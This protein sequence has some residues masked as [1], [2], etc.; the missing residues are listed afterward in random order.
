[1]YWAIGD[2]LKKY[3]AKR[4]IVICGSGYNSLKWSTIISRYSKISF[5]IPAIDDVEINPTRHYIVICEDVYINHSKKL[6]NLGFIEIEDYYDWTKYD[7]TSGH[8]PVDVEYNGI[9]IG[10]GSYFSFQKDNLKNIKTIGRF[11]SIASTAEVHGNHSMNRLTTS[12]LYPLLEEQATVIKNNAPT[13]KDPLGTNRKVDIGNDVWIGANSFIN[14][15]KVSKIG[16]GA[17][18]G[19]GSLVTHDVHPYAI[20]Y[21]SPAKVV[22]YRFSEKQIAVLELVKWWEWDKKQLNENIE[23]LMYPEMFF[24]RFQEKT[25]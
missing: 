8:L 22:R 10:Y 3:L 11:C 9:S 25:K 12:S 4:E 13:D 15:S 21:G 16:N 19:A 7:R 14:S 23:L 2:I 20:V 6:N 18:I 5:T 24:R 1:M 17:I